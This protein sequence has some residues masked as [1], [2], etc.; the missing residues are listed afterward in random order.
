VA[1]RAGPDRRNMRANPD[2]APIIVGAMGTFSDWVSWV[3]FRTMAEEVGD[4][5]AQRTMVRSQLL[6]PRLPTDLRDEGLLSRRP[7]IEG[8]R[9]RPRTDEQRARDAGLSVEQWRRLAR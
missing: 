6:V 4:D 9:H 8:A 5:E 1:L 2:L 7:S 3:R